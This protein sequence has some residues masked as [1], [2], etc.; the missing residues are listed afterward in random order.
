[1]FERLWRSPLCATGNGLLQVHRTCF[2]LRFFFLIFFSLSNAW[3]SQMSTGTKATE[4]IWP[5]YLCIVHAVISFR[6]SFDIFFLFPHLF[7]SLLFC[8][9]LENCC[10]YTNPVL[11]LNLIQLFPYK[12]VIIYVYLD[13]IR[14]LCLSVTASV[15]SCV[16][17]GRIMYLHGFLTTTH[18]GQKCDKWAEYYKRLNGNTFQRLNILWMPLKK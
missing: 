8:L 7:V 11:V 3:N 9:E 15:R 18:F 6:I 13:V 17:G 4:Y 2:I 10:L 12:T 16:G 1:M 14:C 5:L